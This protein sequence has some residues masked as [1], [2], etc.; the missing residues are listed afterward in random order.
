M[1]LFTHNARERFN[2]IDWWQLTCKRPL[3]L[4]PAFASDGQSRCHR[5]PPGR[6]ILRAFLGTLR[7]IGDDTEMDDL[8]VYCG[9]VAVVL[10]VLGCRVRGNTK[11]LGVVLLIVPVVVG[12]FTP[13]Y[14]I[15]YYR[16]LS[17]SACGVAVLA[18][19]GLER[20]GAG[21]TTAG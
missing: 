12:A 8:R 9:L 2:H 13:L 14:L 5:K 11:F 7:V 17:A 4:F 1:E 3:A 15:L 19:L 20:V 21:P 16:V 18:A 6:L 10:A